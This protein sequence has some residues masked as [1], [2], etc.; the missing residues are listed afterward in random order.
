MYRSLMYMFFFHT[1]VLTCLL[2]VEYCLKNTMQNV[3]AQL[4]NRLFV[5]ME[6][7]KL[8]TSTLLSVLNNFRKWDLRTLKCVKIFNGHQDT[9]VA[10]DYCKE[11]KQFA[12][13]SL[14]KSCKGIEHSKSSTLMWYPLSI[15][16]I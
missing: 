14:D 6:V 11:S 12:S 4:N 2:R 3:K 8:Q 1:T 16:I 13:A 7:R 9:V 5:C 10:L 15:Y